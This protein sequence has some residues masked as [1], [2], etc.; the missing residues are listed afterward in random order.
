MKKTD[1]ANSRQNTNPEDNLLFAL[2]MGGIGFFLVFVLW[3][4][5]PGRFISV[6]VYLLLSALTAIGFFAFT[7]LQPVKAAQYLDQSWDFIVGLVRRVFK[8]DK[9]SS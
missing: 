4:L 9:K 7:L 5:I 2:I 8:Q 1:H 6:G 3:F